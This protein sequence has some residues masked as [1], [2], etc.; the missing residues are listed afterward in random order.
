MNPILSFSRWLSARPMLMFTTNCAATISWLL[1][2]TMATA[3]GSWIYFSIAF[4]GLI[5][6]LFGVWA[7]CEKI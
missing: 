2:M 7:W 3:I 4:I 6:A 5:I 1:H